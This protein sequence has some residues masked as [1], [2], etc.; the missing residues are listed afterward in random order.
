MLRKGRSLAIAFAVVAA[1][2]VQFEAVSVKRAQ[3]VGQMS[4]S[5]S[6]GM[7][8]YTH[9][10]FF[11]K[12][13]TAYEI[14]GFSA[15][16]R[17]LEGPGWIATESYD[18]EAKIPSGATRADRARMLQAMLAERFHLQSHWVS[19][20]V[21]GYALVVGKNGPKFKEAKAGDEKDAF[22]SPLRSVTM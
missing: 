22:K 7:L 2:Q 20:E 18:L 12:Q 16:D 10:I 6:P 5:N 3:A 8:K 21:T 14:P 4:V 11:F 17:R 19:R 15:Q 1:A 13:K 9:I